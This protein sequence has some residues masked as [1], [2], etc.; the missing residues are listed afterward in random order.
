MKLDF[1]KIIGAALIYLVAQ[2][3]VWFQHN[4]QFKDITKSPT[5][6]GWYVL[7]IPIT[8][9]FLQATKL[10]VEGFG[11]QLWPNRFVGFV[12]GIVSYIILTNYYF[13][14]PVTPKVAVQLGLCFT[15]IV[16]QV[17]WK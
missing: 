7:A 6:W 10:G 4:W 12:T 2:S 5:W 8:Y 11:N 17:F 14:E 15:I 16:V 3:A 13:S 1:Y 9:L